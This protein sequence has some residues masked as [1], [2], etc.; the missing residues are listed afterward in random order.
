MWIFNRSEG[1]SYYDTWEKVLQVYLANKD[2]V[3]KVRDSKSDPIYEWVIEWIN[4]YPV[5]E[6][7]KVFS[8]YELIEW[9]SEV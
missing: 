9:F 8:D 2:R 7:S 1:C 4:S 6:L 3:S 5:D